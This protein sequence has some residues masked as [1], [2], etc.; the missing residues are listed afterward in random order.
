MVL[1]IVVTWLSLT[2]L[3][4]FHLKVLKK[5]RIKGTYVNITEAMLQ[6][7]IYHTEWRK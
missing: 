5:L 2:N 4:S 3:S 6:A 7:Y 1:K